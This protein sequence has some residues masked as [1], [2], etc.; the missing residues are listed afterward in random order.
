MAASMPQEIIP[1]PY[2]VPKQNKIS[3]FF[4]PSLF[5]RPRAANP[6]L[7]HATKAHAMR[8]EWRLH[9]FSNAP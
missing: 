4:A 2:G 3:L 5:Q 8:C 6:A 1:H 9:T 7:T